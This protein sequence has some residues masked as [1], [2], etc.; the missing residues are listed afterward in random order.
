MTAAPPST[1]APPTPLEASPDPARPTTY[2][3]VYYPGTTIPDEATVI[4]LGTGEEKTGVDLTMQLVPTAR[5]T[6]LVVDPDGRPQDGMATFRLPESFRFIGAEGS[7]RLLVDGWG[8]PP[9]SA[10]DVLGMQR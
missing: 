4:T 7:R 9:G 3:P 5:L 1:G 8:N 10:E 2:A 6:G